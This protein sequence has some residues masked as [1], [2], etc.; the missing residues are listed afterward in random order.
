V[1]VPAPSSVRSFLD[2]DAGYLAWAAA[3][4]GGFV[5]NADRTLSPNSLMLHR[6]SCSCIEGPASPGRTRTA[7]YRKV[8]AADVDSLVDWC[9]T[10]IGVDPGSC[11]H[12]RPWPSPSAL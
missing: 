1:S 11:R 10:D 4:V 3:H 12:C 5:V 2:D 6:A 9:R 8:C 7:N